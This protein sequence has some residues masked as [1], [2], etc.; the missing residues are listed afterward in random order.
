MMRGK[1]ALE[2][3]YS[4]ASLRRYLPPWGPKAGW[5]GLVARVEDFDGERLRQMNELGIEIA[6]LSFPAM[7]VQDIAGVHEAVAT[8]REANDDLAAR[9]AARPD[10]FVGLAA[11]PMQDPGAAVEELCRCVQT[12]GFRG[13]LVNGATMTSDGAGAYYDA[14]QYEEFWQEL[15][16]L[17][18]PLYLHPRNPLP[19]YERAY[20]GRPELIGPTWSFAVETATH[21]LRLLTSGLF[22]RVPRLTLILGHLGEFL[23]FAIERLQQRLDNYEWIALQRSPREVLQEN[24]Y[25]TV[26]GNYHT[27]SL[28][29]TMLQIGA[30]RIM[31]AA[32][33]PYEKMADA[34]LWFD[35]APISEPDKVK[36]GRTNAQ[37]LL[38]L[39]DR[40]PTGPSR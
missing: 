4:P 34:A 31:F 5:E 3:H 11:L 39:Y 33:Y 29:A 7:G 14:P 32:D 24:F 23:P 20:E 16:R 40:S 1:I 22:D 17:D 37:K 21:A 18:V 12:L 13:A 19:G 36:I 26:S 30:D 28:I 38:K 6:A 10:R 8:A 2:E 25:V 27:P 15:A 9:I 35:Q